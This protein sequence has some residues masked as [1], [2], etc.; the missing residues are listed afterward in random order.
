[1]KK[2]IVKEVLDAGLYTKD[3]KK[4]MDL[5]KEAREELIGKEIITN[6]KEQRCQIEEVN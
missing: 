5:T 1:M 4:I 3:G 6:K 2:L